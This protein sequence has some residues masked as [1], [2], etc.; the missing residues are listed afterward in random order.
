M[1]KTY[2]ST[3]AVLFT[4]LSPSFNS[5]KGIFNSNKAPHYYKSVKLT[6]WKRYKLWHQHREDKIL[7][8]VLLWKLICPYYLSFSKHIILEIQT[9]T[10][11]AFC[12]S[13]R[14]SETTCL[15]LS[16]F[17]FTY[18]LYLSCKDKT[19]QQSQCEINTCLG[20][21]LQ[22]K[23]KMFWSL[24]HRYTKSKGT[25][26]GYYSSCKILCVATN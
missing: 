19:E 18:N 23:Y 1:P 8:H 10:E 4:T 25:W 6:I 26:L 14:P 17:L 7:I 3:P 24:T 20:K 13:E 2:C 5:Y 9:R 22:R 11:I 15:W 12:K 21:K 16:S